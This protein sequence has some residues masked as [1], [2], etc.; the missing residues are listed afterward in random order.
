[1]QFVGQQP[2]LHP[3]LSLSDGQPEPPHSAFCVTGR[4]R[5]LL[6]GPHDGEH[7]PYGS[8]PPT[9]QFTVGLPQPTV[10]INSGQ[11]APPP[12]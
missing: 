9:A 2:S 7:A 3:A 4:V 12:H 8:Q 10:S 6:P 5:V 1:M 11:A